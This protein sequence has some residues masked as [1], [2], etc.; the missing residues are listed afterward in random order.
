[1]NWVEIGVINIIEVKSLFVVECFLFLWVKVIMLIASIVLNSI[2]IFGIA[3]FRFSFINKCISFIGE[4][5]WIILPTQILIRDMVIIGVLLLFDLICFI[6]VDFFIG[7][8]IIK[9]NN[10][11]EYIEVKAIISISMV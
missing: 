1:M 10:R 3:C 5:H 8:I 9:I 4:S 2:I 6:V 11:V 7:S